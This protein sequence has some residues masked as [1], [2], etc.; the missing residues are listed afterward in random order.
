MDFVQACVDE[1]AL[2]GLDGKS[3]MFHQGSYTL[4][5]ELKHITMGQR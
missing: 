5:L 4:L 3:F 1:I 2:E